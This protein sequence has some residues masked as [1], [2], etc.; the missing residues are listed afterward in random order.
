M[1]QPDSGEARFAGKR[2]LVVEDEAIVA[3]LLENIL[4]DIG[5]AV[6]G[7]A[8]TLQQADELVA[9][10]SAIDAAILD[11]NLHG[12]RIYPVAEILA[13]RNVPIAFATGY[14]EGGLDGAWRGRPTVQKPYTIADI[15]RVLY[16]FFG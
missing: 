12:E 9:Q 3:M 5:C 14:G 7:P 10:E 6:I 11:V 8:L 15:V 2:V 4:D 13:G 16:G 1:T